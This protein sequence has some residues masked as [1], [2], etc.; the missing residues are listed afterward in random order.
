VVDDDRQVAVTTPVA[1]LIDA[2]AGQIVQ[3]IRG[4][5]SLDDTLDDRT[6]R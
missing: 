4:E 3:S 2:D 1:E 6:D 5:A